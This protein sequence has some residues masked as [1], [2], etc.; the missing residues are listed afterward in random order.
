V[1]VEQAAIREHIRDT[2]ARY[3]IAGDRR[4]LAAFVATFAE[5]AVY[6]SAVFHCVGRAEIHR[7][8][9]DNWHA[10]PMG[11]VARFRRHNLTT[12]Q[13]D[14]T[15]PTTADARTYYLVMSDLG[16][17]HCGFYVDRFCLENAHWLIA[18]REVW[19]DWCHPQSLYVPEASKRLLAEKGTSGPL[20][21]I[22]EGRR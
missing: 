8:L 22:A 15:G 11:P 2:M 14:I 7:Y 21:A 6:E 1:S 18:H 9:S 12:C 4:D 16:A 10:K 3:N 19:M 5:H 13:I 17:D 20:A